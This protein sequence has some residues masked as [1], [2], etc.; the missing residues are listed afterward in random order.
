[1][2]REQILQN[3]QVREQSLLRNVYVWMTLGLG[4]TGVISLGMASNPNL[5]MSLVRNPLLFYGA[6]IGELVLVMF[7]SARLMQMSATAA[8]L[9]FAGYAALNGVT[10][11][12]IFLAYTGQSIAQAFF[13]AGGTFAGMS[14]WATTTRRDLSSI[15]NYLFMGLIGLIIA[16]VAN[17]FFRSD[18]FSL[19]ISLVGVA[20]FLGLTAYDTQMIKSWNRQFG[21]SIDEAGY[22]KLS[23]MGALK[24]YLDFINLFLFFLRIFGRRD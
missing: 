6:I 12:V 10:L 17:M 18:S 9:G 19:L 22:I 5:V 13:V 7:L 1:M 3:A 2:T 14:L 24:L 15:G 4:L 20:L 11:S 16:M 23:I 8:T 21:S